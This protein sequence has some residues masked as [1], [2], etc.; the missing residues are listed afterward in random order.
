VR[1]ELV[2]DVER[3]GEISKAW[4]DL[5]VECQRPYCAPAWLLAWWRHVRPPGAE[6]RLALVFDGSD[7]VGVAPFFISPTPSRMRPY[8]V[9]GAAT[10][11]RVEPCAQR[12]REREV[13]A[14]FADLLASASPRVTSLDFQGIPATSSWPLLLSDGWPG[15]RRP[16]RHIRARTP[17]PT[18]ALEG[19]TYA[20]W[21]AS[22]S[23]NFRQ[24]MRRA[25]RQLEGHGAQFR[26]AK[27]GRELELGLNA[28]TVL[29]RQRWE[30]RGG[31]SVLTRRC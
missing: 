23:P 27:K 18:L 24:Q 4:D 26:I 22:R 1:G 16:S 12:G 7:L 19:R 28:F 25:R 11:V 9:L 3:A 10:I 13:A 30:A 6:F 14:V 17:A 5:A 8:R 31:S 2:H 15:H 29:H 21:F 20:E